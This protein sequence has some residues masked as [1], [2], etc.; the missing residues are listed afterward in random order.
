MAR[1]QSVVVRPLSL[2]REASAVG[3]AMA[4]VAIAS[5]VFAMRPWNEEALSGVLTEYQVLFADLAAPDQRVYRALEE[6]ILESER[7]RA[8]TKRWPFVG[9]LAAQGVP[10]FAADPLDG[11]SYEWA[12][13][14]GPEGYNYLGV[15]KPGG[16]RRSFLVLIQ[17]AEERI[18]DPGL[19][20]RALDRRHR[21]LSDGE[22]IHLGI[23][24][25]DGA[26]KTEAN[27]I[28]QPALEGWREILID[29]DQ[30]GAP[31]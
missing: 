26:P 15:A 25:R 11:P 23:W 13:R 18:D 3:I 7:E 31:P 4:T 29:P 6:G 2:G 24:I 10:P 27:P 22:I 17:E 12:L 20:P 8:R 19:D 28:T 5:T 9:E 16:G 14:E 1:V 30:P 21:V